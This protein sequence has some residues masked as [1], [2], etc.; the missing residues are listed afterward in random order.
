VSESPRIWA[1]LGHR[2]GDNL[3]VLAVARGLGL[4][5]ETRSMR[6]N[7]LR[8]LRKA[9]LGPH[10]TSVLPESRCW[11]GP[12]WPDLVIGVGHRSVPVARYIRKASG[13]RTKLVQ[14]G[15]PRLH[16][17]H[18]NL[19]ITMPQY[20]VPE[21]DNVVRL[22][23][24]MGSP[25]AVTPAAAERDFLDKLPRPHRLMVIGGR[26]KLWLMT[27]E[28]MVEAG[29]RLIAKSDS[30]GGTTLAVGS[31]RTEPLVLDA[32]DALFSGTR[33]ALARGLPS[34]AT[35]LADADELY[36]TADSVSMLSEAIFTGKPVGMIPIRLSPHGKRRYLQTQLGLRKRPVRDLTRVWA[37][38]ESA[39]LVGTI[40]EPIAARA[41]DPVEIAVEAIRPLLD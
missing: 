16:P 37:G 25:H 36:V 4:P 19:V 10:L 1:L 21:A 7:L 14:L 39:G 12:P 34:Y 29:R 40:D 15:N 33:H 35:L 26:T 8:K 27:P 32:L 2:R 23:F 28:D 11:I 38:L 30:D 17:R 3:Q 22:P 41:R 24:A 5:F 9:I 20:R 31:P 13:G 18:F 6:Y